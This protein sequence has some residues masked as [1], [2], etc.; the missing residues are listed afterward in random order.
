MDHCTAIAPCH[1]DRDGEI[2]A[3]QDIYRH[4]LRPIVPPMQK[5]LPSLQEDGEIDNLHLLLLH[6]NPRGSSQH[7]DGVLAISLQHLH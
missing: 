3:I 7:W 5:I 2:Q 1:V 6:Q 4:D